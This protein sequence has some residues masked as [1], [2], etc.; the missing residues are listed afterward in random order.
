MT[1]ET[2]KVTADPNMG[3]PAT[4]RGTRIEFYPQGNQP[5][6]LNQQHYDRRAQQAS[7]M[8]PYL[9]AIAAFIILSLAGIGLGHLYLWLRFG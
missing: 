9:V 4:A 6:D 3:L 2:L 5:P 8:L 1:D 7:A